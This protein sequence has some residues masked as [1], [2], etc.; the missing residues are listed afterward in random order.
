MK[1]VAKDLQ[2]NIP[3]TGHDIIFHLNKISYINI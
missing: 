2:V 3:C 1:L